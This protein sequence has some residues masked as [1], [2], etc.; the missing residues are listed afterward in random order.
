MKLI[1]KV[2]PFRVDLDRNLEMVKKLLNKDDNSQEA[3]QSR[4]KVWDFLLDLEKYKNTSES[5]NK[6]MWLTYGRKWDAVDP[7]IDELLVL[8]CDQ[9]SALV[10]K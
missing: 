2:R 1:N 6:Y 10:T 5:D 4:E 8:I 7:L 3:K 9:D